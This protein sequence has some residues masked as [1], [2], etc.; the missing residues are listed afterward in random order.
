MDLRKT[1]FNLL[2]VG[3]GMLFFI[4]GILKAAALR[5][6][7][8]EIRQYALVPDDAVPLFAV[9][10]VFLEAGCGFALIINLGARLSARI[11]SALVALFMV[12]VSSRVVRGLGG[13]C[14]CFGG[15]VDDPVGSGVLIRD[16]FLLVA[17]MIVA[18]R[19]GAVQ[20][21][22]RSQRGGVQ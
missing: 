2:R 7:M 17:C 5:T 13:G 14:G 19:S 21:G 12:A 4:A 9:I 8:I 18:T 20:P 22:G 16:A 11:L 6:F 15:L 10:L 1:F 3:V